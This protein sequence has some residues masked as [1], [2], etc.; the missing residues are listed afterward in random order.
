MIRMIRQQLW[1]VLVCG[2]IGTA[3]GSY[4]STFD[5]RDADRIAFWW[6]PVVKMQGELVAPP[7]EGQVLIRMHGQKL[8]GEEC[9]YKGLQAFG[10]RAAGPQA[11]LR[12]ARVDLP[13]E[14][15]TKPRGAF[16]IGVWR[17]WPVEGVVQVNVYVMH[18]CGTGRLWATKIAEV[19]L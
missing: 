2:I 8:R 5:A 16:D 6:R 19:P 17:V 12:L 9:A 4:L 14:G 13:E 11:D 3:L 10:D 15:N 18:D 1:F 7:H